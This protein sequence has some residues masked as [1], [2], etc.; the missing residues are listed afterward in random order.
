MKYKEVVVSAVGDKV[1]AT[2]TYTR[3]VTRI[4]VDPE[5]LKTLT[6]PRMNDTASLAPQT[7]PSGL[8]V[9]VSGPRRF[10]L[11]Q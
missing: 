5:F 6:D 1:K 11:Y 3:K 7:V 4:E 9:D 8:P 10:P 2:V